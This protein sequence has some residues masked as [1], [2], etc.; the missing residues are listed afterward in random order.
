MGFGDGVRRAELRKR[1]TEHNPK[2]DISIAC[3][4]YPYTASACDV[5]NAA[6]HIMVVKI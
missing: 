2:I 5:Y 1:E 4:D 3:V 6:I